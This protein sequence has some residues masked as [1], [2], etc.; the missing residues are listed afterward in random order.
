MARVTPNNP[1]STGLAP[2]EPDVAGDPEIAA[3]ARPRG[4]AK[5]APARKPADSDKSTGGPSTV[6]PPPS[7]PTI[8]R[9]NPKPADDD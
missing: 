9:I 3:A 2:D 7:N 5:K 8:A 4:R 6:T 1:F